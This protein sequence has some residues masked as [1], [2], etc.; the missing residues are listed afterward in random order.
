MRSVQNSK[1]IFSSLNIFSPLREA[2]LTP[3]DFKFKNFPTSLPEYPSRYIAK[4]Q[5]LIQNSTF[6]IQNCLIVAGDNIDL[7]V[8]HKLCWCRKFVLVFQTVDVP[9][10]AFATFIVVTDNSDS[11]YDVSE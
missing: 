11:I 5:I 9:M 8:C 7:E 6:K 10:V 3:D 4:D 2:M 1:F